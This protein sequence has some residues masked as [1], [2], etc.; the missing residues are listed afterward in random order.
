MV[1]LNRATKSGVTN[2]PWTVSLTVV[3][4]GSFWDKV[5]EF[6]FSD[7]VWTVQFGGIIWMPPSQQ[8]A[9]TEFISIILLNLRFQRLQRKQVSTTKTWTE[10]TKAEI[11][12]TAV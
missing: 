11:Y 3:R 12:F 6:W 5:A 8:R 2:R 4:N 9:G 1:H 7:Y 10:E